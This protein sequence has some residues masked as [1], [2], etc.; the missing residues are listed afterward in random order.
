MFNNI[1]GKIK[2]LAQ[3]VFW[4]GITVSFLV[5]IILI[6]QDENTVLI[7]FLV[8]VLG[9]LFSLIGSF[10]TYGFGQLIENSDILVA[11]K[12]ADKSEAARPVETINDKIDT[13]SKWKQQ[14]LIT[15]QEYNQK[16][17]NLK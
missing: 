1:G 6:S 13:L 15:E 16:T 5:G 17:E 12:N 4:L 8:L 9:S 2:I 11:E 7:G 3:V 14:G 10:M